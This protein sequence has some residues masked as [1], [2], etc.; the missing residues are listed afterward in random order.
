MIND[1]VMQSFCKHAAEEGAGIGS[2][3]MSVA[4]PTVLGGVA[5][6]FLGPGAGRM[7]GR[8][9]GASKMSWLPLIG[10]PIGRA[11]GGARGAAA[12]AQHGWK[13]GAGLG[14]AVGVVND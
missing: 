2:K 14:A 11:I 5:G 9:I 6:K 10:K 8:E 4:I 7:L 12:G 1:E 3:I 13:V